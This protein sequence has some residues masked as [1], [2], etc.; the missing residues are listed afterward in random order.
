MTGKSNEYIS[1]PEAA[2]ALGVS[3]STVKRWV[4]EGILPA[5][6]TPGGHRKL[7]FAEVLALARQGE[8]PHRDSAG[9]TFAS[10]KHEQADSA[11]LRS[12]LH[13][14]LVR[15][16][17]AQARAVIQGAYR[18]GITVEMLADEVIAP[19]MQ[20]IGHDWKTERIDIW[21]EHRGSLICAAAL[22]ELARDLERRAE[23]PRPVAVGAAPE[24]DPYQLATLLAQLVLL[25]AGWDAVN[26][27]PNTPLA[28]LTDALYS[29]RP[30]LLWVSASHLQNSAHFVRE[31]RTF[32]R[33]AEQSG[34]AVAVGG[35]A[36]TDKLR[37]QL[38]YTTYGDRLSHLAEFAR[39]LHPR[40][41][42]PARGRP[43]K[44]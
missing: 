27:G 43:R 10:R 13:A 34:V 18:S 31:Y 2:Q 39:T 21:H 41:E 26:L 30:R 28:S 20:H 25:D 29:L 38:P 5:H 44:S 22:H 9:I 14:A 24:G 32:Y 36:I 17:A 19:V 11:M 3:V 12:S 23:R 40:K 4:D 1:T 37:S 8:W 15:G 42:R 6:R 7:L 33:I 35:R 16:E